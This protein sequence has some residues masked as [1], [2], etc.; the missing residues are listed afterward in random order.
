MLADLAF[1]FLPVVGS[2]VLTILLDVSL[3][4]EPTLEAL[5]VDVSY[6]AGTLARQDE[7]VVVCL[8][9]TPAKAALNG[10]L[11]LY[12]DIRCGFDGLCL[13]ELLLEELL[14]CEVHLLTTEVFDSEAHPAKLYGVELLN[15]VVKLAFW[16]LQ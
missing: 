7:R 6:C 5:V 2:D 11:P 3:R 12:C 10:I 14:R 15:L 8:L 9:R 13:F 16:V 4:F 1:K